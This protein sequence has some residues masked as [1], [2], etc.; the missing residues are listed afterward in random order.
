MYMSR[1]QLEGK[2][3][4]ISVGHKSFEKVAKFKYLGST[5]TDQNC[6]YEEIR[7]RLNSGNAFYHAVQNPLSSFLLSINVK[8]KIYQS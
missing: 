2:I 4:Y 6:I 1:Q 7:G 5:L 8:I 3:N